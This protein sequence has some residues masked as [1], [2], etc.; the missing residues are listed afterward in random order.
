MASSNP[1]GKSMNQDNAAI[2]TLGIRTQALEGRV[3]ELSSSLNAVQTALSSE[4]RG[5]SQALGAKIDE[6]SRQP[7]QLYV[8]V[9]IGIFS[10]YAYIDNS[11]IGPL[12]EK[13]QDLIAAVKEITGIVRSDMVPNWVHQK[14]WNDTDGKIRSLEASVEDRVKRIDEGARQERMAIVDR[15]KR[16]EDSNEKTWN[17]RDALTILYNRMDKLEYSSKEEQK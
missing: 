14:V 2:A 16:L 15:I 4:I 13:D 3:N 8:S 17:Q 10:L 7:W 11:K 1:S 6:R 9:L 5:I 12:K